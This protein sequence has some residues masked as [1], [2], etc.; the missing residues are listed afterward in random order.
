MPYNT[1]SLIDRNGNQHI[2]DTMTITLKEHLEEV[3]QQGCDLCKK[4]GTDR[5]QINYC[6]AGY[7]CGKISDLRFYWK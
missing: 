3:I 1:L 5:F 4:Y 7:P 6:S 2:F